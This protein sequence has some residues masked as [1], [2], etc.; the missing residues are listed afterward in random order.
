[1]NHTK[2]ERMAQNHKYVGNLHTISNLLTLGVTIVA[3]AGFG[4]GENMLALNVFSQNSSKNQETQ[5]LN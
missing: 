3:C 4:S 5:F 1:M 2:P